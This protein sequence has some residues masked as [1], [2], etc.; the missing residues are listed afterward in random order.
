MDGGR[1]GDGQEGGN[2]ADGTAGSHCSVPS[3]GH[4]CLNPNC[5]PQPYRDTA[6]TVYINYGSMCSNAGNGG[7]GGIGGLGSRGGS[8]KIFKLNGSL[9]ELVILNQFGNPG[10]P[11]KDGNS[12][13][14]GK[15]SGCYYQCRRTYYW[16]SWRCCKSTCL[17]T[18]CDYHT[19]DQDSWLNDLVNSEQF[20][21][22][23]GLTPTEKNSIGQEQITIPQKIIS[24]LLKDAKNEN[25]Q[26]GF[27]NFYSSFFSALDKV[28]L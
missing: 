14:G 3:S 27:S 25:S 6:Y 15:N 5:N 9:S 19:C 23:N 2:G 20:C 1:G 26:N 17:G 7:K 16:R 12:G 11:G 28:N 8:A 22:S 24:Q 18:C 13:F 10:N 21:C 4:R